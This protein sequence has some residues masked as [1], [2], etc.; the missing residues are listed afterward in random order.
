MTQAEKDVLTDIVA[1]MEKVIKA[2]RDLQSPSGIHSTVQ[3]PHRLD[4][5]RKK[6]GDL[7]AN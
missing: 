7:P 2:V 6:I 1:E 3:L 5:L 4:S